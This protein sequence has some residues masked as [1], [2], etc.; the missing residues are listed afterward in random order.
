MLG[1]VA[2]SSSGGDASTSSTYP[3]PGIALPKGAQVVGR[4]VPSLESLITDSSGEFHKGSV[5]SLKLD[6]SAR[7]VY[8]TV[9]ASAK[10]HGY[11]DMAPVS[12]ACR[13][14]QEQG[15]SG[16]GGDSSGRLT[17][18]AGRGARSDGIRLEV[19]LSSCDQ[20]KDDFRLG[21]VAFR[22]DQPSAVP[23]G[24]H[25]IDVVKVEGPSNPAS[26]GRVP[27]TA[28]LQEGWYYACQANHQVDL[29]I[30]GSPEAAWRGA[31]N[32]MGS[33]EGAASIPYRGAEVRQAS[34]AL[35]GAYQVLV[36]DMGANPD[37]MLH[38]WTCED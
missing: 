4:T 5:T 14:S 15:P 32:A 9:L 28:V 6:R 31:L 8:A 11:S 17:T 10:R 22:K 1:L 37:P 30:T 24:A 18:C 19:E 34:S 20:C 21:R 38:F 13:E 27:G 26:W 16:A 25:G 2:C 12:S 33:V 23:P 36:L 3:A 29:T 7:S 35:D